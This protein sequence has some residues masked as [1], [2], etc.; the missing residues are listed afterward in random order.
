MHFQLT[1]NS[2]I[3]LG[4]S[5]SLLLSLFDNYVWYKEM[6]MSVILISSGLMIA[7]LMYQLG[8]C[9]LRR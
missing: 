9:F 3:T 2:Y 6:C 8:R 1:H 4:G 5:M 7:N